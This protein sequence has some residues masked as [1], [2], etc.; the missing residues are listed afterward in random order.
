MSY[1]LWNSNRKSCSLLSGAVTNAIS[2]HLLYYIDKINSAE[3][4][5]Q[6]HAI[7]S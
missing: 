3:H 6:F 5:F 7:T 2:G 1:G 4:H